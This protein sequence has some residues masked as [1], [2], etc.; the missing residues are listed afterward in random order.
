M[1]EYLGTKPVKI[2]E[3]FLI[4]VVI[5]DMSSI[6]RDIIRNSNTY[7]K[8]SLLSSS[9]AKRHNAAYHLTRTFFNVKDVR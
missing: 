6:S 3:D 1:E 2:S 7:Y 9:K 5:A 8:A 4:K